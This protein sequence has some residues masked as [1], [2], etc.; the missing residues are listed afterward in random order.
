V[1]GRRNIFGILLLA[2]LG[3]CSKEPP[4]EAYFGGM[5]KNPVD[6]YVLL[7]RNYIPA[8]H[9]DTFRLDEYGRFGHKIKI[10]SADMY[11]FH[12]GDQI[13]MCYLRPGD[14]LLV[15]TN[16]M[17][18]DHSM[19]FSGKGAGFNNLL[20]NLSLI[21]ANEIGM[22]TNLVYR[23]D[24]EMLLSYINQYDLSKQNEIQKYL[25]KLPDD[26]AFTPKEEKVLNYSIYFPD[27]F[28]LEGYN[29]VHPEDTIVYRFPFEFS[30]DETYHPIQYFLSSY[31]YKYMYR[32]LHLRD[33]LTPEDCISIARK[34][35]AIIKDTVNA[36]FV[37]FQLIMNQLSTQEPPPS[38]KQTRDILA[39][40]PRIFH[41]SQDYSREFVNLYKLYPHVLRFV[42][43]SVH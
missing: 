25:A 17:S 35:D 39:V 12:H 24:K 36:E 19:Q 1:F 31:L 2:F 42:P 41:F 43:D 40:F 8:G 6:Q 3:A 15:Y 32:H 21:S 38:L 10:D 11:F 22:L 30:L 33:S 28:L 4:R 34:V 5:I 20:L 9:I 26:Y 37:K 27:F 18:F 23:T 7:Y 13:N 29:T 16:M 14:S